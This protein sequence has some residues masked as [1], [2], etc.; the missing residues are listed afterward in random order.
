M[1]LV[2]LSFTYKNKQYKPK[3]LSSLPTVG[4]IVKENTKYSTSLSIEEQVFLQTGIPIASLDLDSSLHVIRIDAGYKKVSYS[5]NTP[6][7]ELI[8]HHTNH[9][10]NN[11][12]VLNL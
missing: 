2:E 11:Y 8:K 9:I 3:V 5:W 10:K 7:K 1:N 4:T 6:A 12:L